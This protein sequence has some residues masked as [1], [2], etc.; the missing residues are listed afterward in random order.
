MWAAV[1]SQE[2]IWGHQHWALPS[3]PPLPSSS[4]QPLLPSTRQLLWF[5]QGLFVSGST[6]T[7]V[8]VAPLSRPAL[9]RLLGSDNYFFQM[10]LKPVL[11]SLFTC[12]WSGN[13][14]K[15]D[16]RPLG[17][18]V[19]KARFYFSA[20]WTMGNLFRTHRSQ[21]KSASMMR[22]LGNSIK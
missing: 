19:F 17:L 20:F 14:I 22:S 4:S 3:L 2:G 7:R 12:V 15:F 13:I 1:S 11:Y 8:G 9:T 10:Q 6:G 16:E 5:S 21:H 18:A